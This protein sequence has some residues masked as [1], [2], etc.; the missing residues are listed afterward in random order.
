MTNLDGLIDRYGGE[1]TDA[2]YG[3]ALERHATDPV[4]YAKSILER[5][6]REGVKKDEPAGN[7][8]LICEACHLPAYLDSMVVRDCRGVCSVCA[9]P[10][11][12]A[13]QPPL[14]GGTRTPEQVAWLKKK[15]ELEARHAAS[16]ASCFVGIERP[17]TRLRT[18]IAELA[19][20]NKHAKPGELFRQALGEI[21]PAGL[22]YW[23]G[24]RRDDLK[25]LGM[26][27][28]SAPPT[29]SQQPRVRELT[30]T[31]LAVERY[32]QRAGVKS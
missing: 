11:T 8:K 19:Q 27:P 17:L 7:D 30:P 4:A 10:A 28:L 1:A 29:T 3:E 13:A 22:V 18:R 12:G 21:A 20:V 6:E 31:A 24:S 14:V 9:G 16:W 26:M 32:W 23:D 25:D 2:A 5:L 15:A